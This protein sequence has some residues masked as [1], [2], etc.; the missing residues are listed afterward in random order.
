VQKAKDTDKSNTS[1]KVEGNT[2][3]N[4]HFIPQ[5]WDLTE[6]FKRPIREAKVRLMTKSSFWLLSFE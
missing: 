1:Q 4:I 3:W 5:R 2:Y 6:G